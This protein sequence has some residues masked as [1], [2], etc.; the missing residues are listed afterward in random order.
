MASNACS[1]KP[2]IK[3]LK[4]DMRTIRQPTMVSVNAKEASKDKDKDKERKL[5]SMK[6]KSSPN[7]K[8]YSKRPEVAEPVRV[9][10]TPPSPSVAMQPIAKA[11]S[12]E[13]YGVL[14]KHL[15]MAQHIRQTRKHRLDGAVSKMRT[16]ELLTTSK[17]LKETKSPHKADNAAPHPTRNKNQSHNSKVFFDKYLKFAYDLSKPDGVRQLEAHF[18]PAEHYQIKKNANKNDSGDSSEWQHSPDERS[19]GK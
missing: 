1:R 13:Q 15:E 18:F 9:T 10:P 11:S 17:H 14:S 16:D 4:L 3:P 6:L 8:Q 12:I 5:K 19:T 7:L 2:S